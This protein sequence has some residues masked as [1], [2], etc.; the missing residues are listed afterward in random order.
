MSA[1]SRAK[2]P[3]SQS[4]LVVAMRV[5][6]HSCRK[7][8]LAR[9]CSEMQGGYR[10]LLPSRLAWSKKPSTDGHLLK[11]RR[12]ALRPSVLRVLRLCHAQTPD[13]LG[14]LVMSECLVD[15]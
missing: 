5:A 3:Q 14:A 15:L 10:H 12:P 6:G 7:V 1:D 9:S 4:R 2:L 8:G 11:T 13:P